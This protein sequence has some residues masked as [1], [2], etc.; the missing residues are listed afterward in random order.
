MITITGNKIVLTECEEC[1][2][3][4]IPVIEYKGRYLCRECLEKEL[5]GSLPEI[6]GSESDTACDN[7]HTKWK[8]CTL[9]STDFN[10]FFTD[11]SLCKDCLGEYLDYKFMRAEKQIKDFFQL[12]NFEIQD[13][14]RWLLDIP[15]ETLTASD[16]K[17]IKTIIRMLH[18]FS[19]D[20][21]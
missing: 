8:D 2:K 9:Y 4:D 12:S 15:E 16:R 13:A 17:Q 6:I 1:F 11:K 19:G 7:C 10:D 21:G 20:F 18:I 14:I 5:L 3:Q